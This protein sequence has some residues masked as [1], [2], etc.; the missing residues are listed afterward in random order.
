MTPESSSRCGVYINAQITTNM[1]TSK[2]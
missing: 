1:L 2:C